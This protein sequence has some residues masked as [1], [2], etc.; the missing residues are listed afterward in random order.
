MSTYNTLGKNHN[1]LT[2]FLFAL[3]NIIMMI[4]LSLYTIVD[5]SFV[6]RYVGIT[7]LSAI[8]MAYPAINFELAISIMIATGGS[9][10]IARQLGEGKPEKARQNFTFLVS[11]NL[12]I[13]FLIAIFGII[14]VNQ[15]VTLLGATPAQFQL[16]KEYLIIFFLFSPCYFLQVSYQTFFVTAGKPVI[17]LTTIVLSG[18]TNIVLDYIF[19]KHLN[20]GMKGTAL[21]TGIGYT[22]SATVGSLYFIKKRTSDLYFVKPKINLKTL[23]ETCINGSSEMVT[24]LSEAVTTFLFNYSF[25]KYYGEEGVASITIILYFQFIMIA[26]FFGFSNGISPIISYKYGEKNVKQ[27]KKLIKM[28]LI[29]IL[30]SSVLVITLAQFL[31]HPVLHFFTTDALV[32]EITLS[33]FKKYSLCFWFMGTTIFASAWF[34]ALSDGKTSAIISFLRGLV[35]LSLSILLL[36]EM[37]GKIGLWFSVPFSEF[38]GLT[39]AV[40]LLIKYKKKYNY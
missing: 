7:A 40:L 6:S 3:P 5:G 36:P 16:C 21:A 9:A 14:F 1:I 27:L 39:V 29:T 22:F 30:S 38:L 2:L 35:F 20:M 10:I 24:N 25:L 12:L 11:T 31:I 32:S 19:M 13:G 8:N 33:G 37:F 15:I 34:T 18:I 17:G 23:S 28:G 4:F 26:V